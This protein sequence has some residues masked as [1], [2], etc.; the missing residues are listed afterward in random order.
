MY[1]YIYI[2]IFISGSLFNYCHPGPQRVWKGGSEQQLMTPL[3][4]DCVGPILLCLKKLKAPAG[5]LKT[6]IG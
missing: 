3:P 2:Y 5:A 1:I 4:E 6:I